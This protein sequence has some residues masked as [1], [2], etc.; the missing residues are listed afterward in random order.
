MIKFFHA[1]KTNDH[2][3]QFQV[4]I[5]YEPFFFLNIR[6]HQKKPQLIIISLEMYSKIYFILDTQSCHIFNPEETKKKE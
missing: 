5:N 4:C 2:L 6:K 3:N 1:I